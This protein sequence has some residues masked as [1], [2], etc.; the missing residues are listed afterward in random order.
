MNR[1]GAGD[2]P[3]Q[4]HGGDGGDP[5]EGTPS[6]CLGV[7]GSRKREGGSRKREGG[8]RKKGMHYFYSTR[9]YRW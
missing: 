1:T 4:V 2:L 8:S 3:S 5:E 6:Q 7:G 9:Q